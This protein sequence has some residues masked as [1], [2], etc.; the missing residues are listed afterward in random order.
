MACLT[1][2]FVPQN[3]AI[4]DKIILIPCKVTEILTKEGFFVMST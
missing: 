3:M 1:L 4:D 2:F